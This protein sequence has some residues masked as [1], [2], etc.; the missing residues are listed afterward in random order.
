MPEEVPA[1]D[2]PTAVL[3]PQEVEQLFNSLKGLK[4]KGFS[5][6][7]ISHKL[8]EV[9]AITDQVTVLR[10]KKVVGTLPTQN[11]NPSELARMMVGRPTFGVTRQ[12]RREGAAARS[13]GSGRRYG[14]EQ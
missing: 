5:V 1:T 9:M 2:E 8:N 7:F 10:L 6:V 3:T 4:E 14:F 13:P 11:T 12:P